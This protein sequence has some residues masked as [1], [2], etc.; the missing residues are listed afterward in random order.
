[1]EKQRGQLMIDNW[2]VIPLVNKSV[3]WAVGPAVKQWPPM[4]NL[5]QFK[6]PEYAIPAK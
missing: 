6:N 5:L 1:M 2:W 3:V 4:W